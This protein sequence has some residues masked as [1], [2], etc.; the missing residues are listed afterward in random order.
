MR[1]RPSIVSVL[2]L[3]LDI[4]TILLHGNSRF[5]NVHLLKQNA[6]LIRL[7]A[8]RSMPEGKWH[9]Q[10]GPL[11]TD[12]KE[13]SGIRHE[14]PEGPPFIVMNLRI[15]CVLRYRLDVSARYRHAVVP[16]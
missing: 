16:L 13:P 4:S 1:H 5:F 3:I 9:R 7:R 10:D 11:Y 14:V 2:Y 12:K 6:S 8:N 15:Y